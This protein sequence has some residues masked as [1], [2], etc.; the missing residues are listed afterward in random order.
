MKVRGVAVCDL[1]PAPRGLGAHRHQHPPADHGAADTDVFIS[2]NYCYLVCKQ[3]RP[4]T[5]FHL[6]VPLKSE[7]PSKFSESVRVVLSV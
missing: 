1:L 3:T 2:L 5:F 7:K 6:I 4:S